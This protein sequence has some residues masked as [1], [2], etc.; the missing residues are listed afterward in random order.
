MFHFAP[1]L[2]GQA[3]FASYFE[4]SRNLDFSM[5]FFHAAECD[6]QLWTGERH[7]NFID[8]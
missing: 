4:K 8:G 1:A 5:I 2:I 3:F 7:G 6:F